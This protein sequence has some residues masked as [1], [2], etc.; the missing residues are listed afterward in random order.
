MSFVAA[1]PFE[2][3]HAFDSKM[4]DV[5]GGVTLDADHGPKERFAELKLHLVQQLSEQPVRIFDPL[6]L[7]DKIMSI[8]VVRPGPTV[9]CWSNSMKH[10]IRS[11]LPRSV[12]PPPKKFV[13]VVNQLAIKRTGVN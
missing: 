8:V 3:G 13:S 7:F 9:G 6:E 4:S 1:R 2:A 12:S 5:S 10:K 11:L